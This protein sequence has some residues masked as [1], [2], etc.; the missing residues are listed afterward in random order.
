MRY[1][2]LSLRTFPLGFLVL[3]L[4]LELFLETFLTHLELTTAYKLW[5]TM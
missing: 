5:R 1:K 2:R 3:A 4:V